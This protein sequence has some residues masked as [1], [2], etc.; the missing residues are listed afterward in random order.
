[1]QALAPYTLRVNTAPIHTALYI[2]FPRAIVGSPVRGAELARPRAHLP[3]WA[4]GLLWPLKLRPFAPT[5]VEASEDRCSGV[6]LCG[7]RPPLSGGKPFSGWVGPVLS[8]PVSLSRPK[9]PDPRVISHI[10][11]RPCA[12]R[13]HLGVNFCN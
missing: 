12:L 1:M 9:Q 10:I 3:D 4:H 2:K 13:E 8:R 7:V 5:G 6:A 11:N